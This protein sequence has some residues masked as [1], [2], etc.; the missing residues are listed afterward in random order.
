MVKAKTRYLACIVAWIG[1]SGTSRADNLLFEDFESYQDTAALHAGWSAGPAAKAA[2]ETKITFSGRQS[3]RC[4]LSASDRTAT[5]RF[6]TAQDWKRV[7]T[8]SFYVAADRRTEL[9]FTCELLGDDGKPLASYSIDEFRLVPNRWQC[10]AIGLGNHPNR[11]LIHAVRLGL[12]T[13][14]DTTVYLDDFSVSRVGRWRPSINAFVE[15]D[16]QSVPLRGGHLFGGSSSIRRWD[17]KRWFPER[18]PLN[19][20]FG[21][22]QISDVNHYCESLVF[23]HTPQAMVFYCGDNDIAAGKSPTRVFNDFKAFADRVRRRLPKTHLIYIPIKPSVA[24]WELWPKMR[25]ANAMIQKLAGSR[26]H[27][28]YADTATP[29]LDR[30]GQ[31]QPGLFIKDGLHLNDEGYRIWARVVEQTIDGISE[32]QTL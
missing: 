4:E 32:Q 14:G 12:T 8:L 11:N 30:E 23:R 15:Q 20:G 18:F 1:V 27:L 9:S 2:I 25:A 21:G 6:K 17:L 26:P 24:R 16:N 31:P 22:S 19:R 10:A 13:T 29:M 3:L 28:H 5:C 7:D